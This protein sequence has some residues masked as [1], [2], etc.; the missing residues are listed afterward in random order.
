MSFW[1]KVGKA[2]LSVGEYA[3][4][5]AKNQYDA[6]KE[7]TAEY[8]DEMPKLRD[9]QLAEIALNEYL[10]K[11]SPLRVIAARKELKKRGFET[12]E[13]IRQI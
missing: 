10:K 12:L 6:A 9:D 5:E 8:A 11:S 13:D 3:A 4:K 2:A 7:R 1:N